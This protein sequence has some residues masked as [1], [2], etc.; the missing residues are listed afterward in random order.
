MVLLRAVGAAEYANSQG[1]L[2]KFCA[3][4]G[5]R[6]KAVVEIRKL[7]Q[8]LTNEI[9]RTCQR[10]KLKPPTDL[11]A[12]LLRQIL[13]SGMGDQLARK[14]QPD[15]VKVGEDK[16]KYKYAYQANNMEEPVFLHQSSVLKKTL[17]EFVI[18]Q[19][20]YETN[21]IYMRGVT[22]VEAEWLPTCVPSLCNL[23]EPL[24]S[25]EPVFDAATGK[26][27]KSYETN[28]YDYNIFRQS[29]SCMVTGTF[30]P[31]AWPLP[32]I[33]MPY[34]NSVDGYKWFARFFLEGKVFTRLE[35]YSKNLLSQPNIMVKSWAKLQSR[36]EALLKALLGR[37]CCSKQAIEN[38]WKDT[39]QYLLVEY[40]KWLPESA[41]GEVSLIWPPLDDRNR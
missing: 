33:E 34:P 12:K 10:L 32:R 6:H 28:S 24:L 16:A 18:Y 40:L 7:R 22:A 29:V 38:V 25:P 30:G 9:K 27:G 19:E 11:Q 35:K 5:L 14:I 13:L 3:D 21:K 4:N 26:S 23:S 8:Q 37:E 41:H 17:P 15:E 39:P 31:Q 1:K 2:E 20:I 36:T